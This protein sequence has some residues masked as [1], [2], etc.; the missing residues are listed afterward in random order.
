MS[1]RIAPLVGYEALNVSAVVAT[2]HLY[3]PRGHPMSKSKEQPN[4][5]ELLFALN[6]TMVGRFDALNERIDKLE[7][8]LTDDALALSSEQEALIAGVRQQLEH[9]SRP[10][11]WKEANPSDRM[12][13]HLHSLV[14]SLV[15]KSGLDP[16]AICNTTDEYFDDHTPV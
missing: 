14:W 4:I 2:F 13:L 9:N 12:I 10:G 7:S 15:A 1:G 3:P 5:N 6:E 8:T 11:K 16:Q